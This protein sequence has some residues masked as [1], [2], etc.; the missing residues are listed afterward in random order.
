MNNKLKTLLCLPLFLIFLAVFLP[1]G[2]VFAAQV[3][4]DN[5]TD[6]AQQEQEE[7]FEEQFRESGAD[8]L[9]GELPSGTADKL[10]DS[11]IS[12]E[13]PESITS[14]KPQGVLEGIIS[15]FRDELARPLKL[16]A[17]LAGVILFCALAAQ[18]KASHAESQLTGV[19]DFVSIAAVSSAL[20]SPIADC[21]TRTCTTIAE[22]SRFMLCYV[23]VYAGILTANGSPM[24]GAT[25][26]SIVFFAMQLMAKLAETTIVPLM[27]IFLALS[28]TGNLCPTLNISGV[29]KAVRTAANWI[30]GLL[31]TIF[32]GLV[33]IQ[34]IVGTS[35]DTVTVR[36]TKYVISSFVP[37]VGSAIS[38]ALGSLQSCLGL[39]KT[40]VGGFGIAVAVLTI[41]PVVLG[42]LAYLLVI[43]LGKIL[44][45]VFE[46]QKVS[47]LLDAVK[48]T[49]TMLMALLLFLCAMI[50]ISTTIV[51]MVGMNM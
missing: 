10:A 20:M 32:V 19:F 28:V 30:M 15:A 13:D 17:L 6:V 37:V 14:V 27:G 18:L 8:Q 40:G 48:S 1:N 9:Y 49:M 36:T 35:A 24:T 50:L 29:T 4:A 38:D 46:I 23:P 5:S 31:L 16:L 7:L 41:V 3:S 33:T 11:G 42:I 2:Q 47:A 39:L 26:N 44:A 21:I 45:D 51:M 22:S 12:A 25:Y 34:S 43:S